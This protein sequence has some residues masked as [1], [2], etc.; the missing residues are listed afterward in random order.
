MN[1]GSVLNVFDAFNPFAPRKWFKKNAS[2][3]LLI[4]TGYL[5]G[6]T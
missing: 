3:V 5:A 4:K 1:I 6:A 2:I